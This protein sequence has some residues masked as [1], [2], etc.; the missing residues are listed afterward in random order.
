MLVNNFI[1]LY[2]FYFSFIYFLAS[3]NGDMYIL[4][5]PSVLFT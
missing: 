4:I 5:L 2:F 1:L 3:L